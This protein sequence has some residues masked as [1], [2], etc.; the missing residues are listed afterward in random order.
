MLSAC[1]FATLLFHPLSPV[2]AFITDSALRRGLMGC[3]MGLTAIAIIYSPPGKRSGAHINPSVTLTFFRL[4]KIE[5]WDALFYTL[6]QFAGG[7]I[8]VLLAALILGKLIADPSV[9]YVTTLPGSAGL[10]VAFLA[11]LMI[12]FILMSVVLTISNTR[13]FNRY[14]GLFAG[15]LVAVYI[16]IEAPLSGMSMNPARTF[17][18]ALSAQDWT[19]LWIY[20]SAPP[21]GMLMAAEAYTR[22]KGRRAVICAKL[23]HRNNQRCIFKCSY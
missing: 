15:L 2:P 10:L 22:I 4:G 3:A 23:H 18:S 19:A 12:S 7:I 8:G 14:T 11:E 20:F 6:A 1:A 16:S 21:V 9:N 5:P 17:G 13:R